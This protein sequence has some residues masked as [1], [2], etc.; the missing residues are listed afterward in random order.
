M[1][2]RALLL[3]VAFL[4]A[5]GLIKP[6]LA[7]D[8]IT[9]DRLEIAI[10]PE[11]DRP[12]VLVI[13]RVEISPEVA[14]PADLAIRIPAAAGEPNAVAS[15]QLD[16]ALYNLAYERELY[17]DWAVIHFT[18]TT[19]EAQLEYYDPR[20][21]KDGPS[22]HFEFTWPGDY[23]VFSTQVQVQQPF[24]ARVLEISPEMGPGSTGSDNLTYFVAD[25]GAQGRDE[26]FDLVMDYEKDSDALTV[27]FLSV[28]PSAPVG[29]TTPGR[30][31]LL[32]AWPWGLV[33]LGLLLVMGAGWWFLRSEPR[34]PKR[35]V[36]RRSASVTP[37]VEDGGTELAVVYC[38]Q[39]GKRAAMGDRFCRA[40]GTELRT[41]G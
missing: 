26:E 6:A 12:E 9:L 33:L 41:S 5:F 32:D 28:Q 29:E 23:A 1:N 13:Y 38:H 14:L 34:A 39:C 8:N 24:D 37:A 35:R 15:R 25:L 10:W 36:R 16:G 19:P 17:G 31:R 27:E 11:Y 18:A 40:C 4:L 21:D 2:L 7:Q 3:I 20:L 30:V 22:R